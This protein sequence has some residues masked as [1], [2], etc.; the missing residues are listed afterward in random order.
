MSQ[1]SHIHTAHLYHKIVRFVYIRHVK[2]LGWPTHRMQA[3]WWLYEHRTI[4]RYRDYAEKLRLT[5]EATRAWL[6]SIDEHKH[7]GLPR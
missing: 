6:A 3:V 2:I 5:V 1:V 7:M 4:E